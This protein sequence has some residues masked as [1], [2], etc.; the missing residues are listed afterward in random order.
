MVFIEINNQPDVSS[1][2]TSKSPVQITA[3]WEKERL[4][5]P[6]YTVLYAMRY[7][8]VAKMDTCFPFHKQQLTQASC[9]LEGEISII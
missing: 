2:S 3:I 1:D 7:T 8:I 6:Q 5:F 4:P 9:S